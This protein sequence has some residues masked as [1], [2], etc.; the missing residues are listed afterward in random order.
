MSSTTSPRPFA[1]C[2]ARPPAGFVPPCLPTKAPQP[3][4]GEAWLHEIKHDGLPRHRAQGRPHGLQL[5][6]TWPTAF[7]SSWRRWRGSDRGP[8]LS[9]VRRWLA[10]SAAS[11][12]SIVSDTA[13]IDGCVFLYAFDLIELSGDDL[14]RDPLAS[15]PQGAARVSPGQG[16][17]PVQRAQWN[18]MM[19]RSCFTTPPPTRFFVRARTSSWNSPRS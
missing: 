17:R 8:Y 13:E 18:S 14:R 7:R 2:G 15:G 12:L 9:T 6:W 11:R 4:T 5:Q 3:P 19:V 10:T 1:V 16:R